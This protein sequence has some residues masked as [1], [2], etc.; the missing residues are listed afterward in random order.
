MVRAWGR[1]SRGAAYF[2]KIATTVSGIPLSCTFCIIAAV[3]SCSASLYGQDA[4]FKVFSFS[5]LFLYAASGMR[6]AVLWRERQFFPGL[7]LFSELLTYLSAVC[8]FAL[9]YGF[10]GN[11]N[12]LGAVMGVLVVSHD[13]VGSL[14]DG[15][16][17]STKA[18][19]SR[20]CVLSV[21]LLVTSH[22]R[23]GILAATVSCVVVCTALR[24]YQAL[25]M[26]AGTGLLAAVVMVVVA[27][28]AIADQ[29]QSLTSAFI[30][31]GHPESGLLG[32]RRSAWEETVSSVH[33]HP[34]FGTGFGTSATET[35]VSEIGGYFESAS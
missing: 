25:L 18:E 27:S 30:Y 23:A 16:N 33:G 11:P 10:F 14:H 22:A 15:G 17:I 32:S 7:L 31:K 19:S 5:L 9:H 28:P 1:R 20:S 4:L 12:S 8:Y 21:L 2:L 6:V 3:A 35:G 29:P 26:L 13:D 24:R 34:W